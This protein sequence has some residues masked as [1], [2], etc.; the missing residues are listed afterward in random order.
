M[1]RSNYHIPRIILALATAMLTISGKPLCAAEPADDATGSLWELARTKA[2]VHRFSTLMTAQDVRRL[3]AT[4]DAVT[5]ELD[6]KTRN[7]APRGWQHAWQ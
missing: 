1:N 3:L 4:D 5:V 6:G 2:T 7:I